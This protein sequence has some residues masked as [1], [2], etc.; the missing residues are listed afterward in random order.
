MLLFES[1]K[2]A[3]PDPRI[4]CGINSGKDLKKHVPMRGG[5]PVKNKERFIYF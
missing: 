5:M 4:E 2:K 1:S 3:C